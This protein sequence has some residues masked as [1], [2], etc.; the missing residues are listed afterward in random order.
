MKGHVNYP[1]IGSVKIEM[2]SYFKDMFLIGKKR[3][4]IFYFYNL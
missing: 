3:V 2:L 1:L 4:M